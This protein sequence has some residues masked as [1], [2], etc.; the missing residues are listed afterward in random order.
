MSVNQFESIAQIARPDIFD[1]LLLNRTFQTYQTCQMSD[2]V[3]PASP[4][5][6]T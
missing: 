3:R 2:I 4:E 5:K 6:V 1:F